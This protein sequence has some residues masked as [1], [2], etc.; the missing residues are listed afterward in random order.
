[1]TEARAAERLARTEAERVEAQ[2]TMSSI[3]AARPR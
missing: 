2:H 1:V 3:E